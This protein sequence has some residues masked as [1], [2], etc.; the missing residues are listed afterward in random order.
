M[1][2]AWPVN[3]RMRK[4]TMVYRRPFWRAAGF[5]GQVLD[6]GGA[7]LWSADNSPPDAS[8]GILTCFV[9]EGALPGDPA[10][11]KPLLAA[12]YAKAY[13]DE[14]LEPIGYHEID[15]GEE[16]WT[17]SCTSP[18]PPGFLTR[19]GPQ[20][21]QA[22]GRIHWSGTDMAEIPP[23]S[24]DGAIR[25]GRRAATEALYALSRQAGA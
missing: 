16:E 6:I 18:Y 22:M 13:G 8:V 12:T 4:A 25:T 11:A 24:M 23:S 14:A 15:W 21:R 9:R 20:M 5:N 19:W 7:L 17:L 1:Q 3:A 10:V 2:T